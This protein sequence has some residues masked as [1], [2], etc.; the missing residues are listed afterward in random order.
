MG[1]KTI[2]C[3]G[4]KKNFLEILYI[5]KN[6]ASN[7]KVQKMAWVRCVCGTE[8]FIRVDNFKSGTTKSC[9]CKRSFLISKGEGNHGYSHHALWDIYSSMKQRCKDKSQQ[10]YQEYG[11][12][13]IVVC[14]HWLE[15]N[16]QGFLNFLEDMGDRPEGMT[17][18][19]IDPN[20]NYC[21]ENCRWKSRSVQSFNTRTR[22]DNVLGYTGVGLSENGEKYLARIAVGGKQIHLGTFLYLE[23][24]IIARREAELKYYG[25]LKPEARE[26][27]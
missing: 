23:S 26:L 6:L 20:G 3:V 27:Q 17:L 8:K 16:G 24:A 13:G 21:K 25:E 11:G 12:R 22:K 2:V 1:D 9:G 10:A 18:D 15:P 14:D 4:D 7:N 5:V 19:R